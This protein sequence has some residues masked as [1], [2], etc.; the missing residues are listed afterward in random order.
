M[1]MPLR[2]DYLSSHFLECIK[3]G[4]HLATF[5]MLHVNLNYRDEKG[6]NALYFAIENNH[7]DNVIFLI[8]NGTALM[9]S[10]KN[11][12]LFHAVICDDLESV[13]LLISKGIDIDIRDD[14][15]KTPMMCAV[16]HD[17]ERIFKYLVNH[18]ADILKMDVKHNMA[19]DYAYRCKSNLIQEILQW[20]MVH[21]EGKYEG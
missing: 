7:S 21:E 1:T 8:Q 15:Y 13:K 4:E 6:R 19:I 14:G 17:R 5:D 18:G 2:G 10:P 16:Y 20:R 3:K 12:A 9:V 11:H